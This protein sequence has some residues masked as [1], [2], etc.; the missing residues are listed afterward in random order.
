M[1][2]GGGL[3]SA[4]KPGVARAA[5]FGPPMSRQRLSD[6]VAASI[7]STIVKQDL[8]PGDALPSQRDLGEQ[9]G[10]SRSVIREAVGALE[11]RG[12]IEV[13]AGSGL[14]LVSV[15]ATSVAESLR[16][17]VRTNDVLDYGKVH[18]VRA[19]V[20]T[21]VAEVAAQRATALDIETIRHWRDKQAACAD[22]LEAAAQCDLEFHRAIAKAADNELYL[23]LLDSI[24]GAL[25]DIRRTLMPGRLRKT[26]RAHSKIVD[27]I[28][29]GD[30]PGA[31]IAMQEHLDTV[32]D[33]WRRGHPA[34]ESS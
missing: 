17:F 28:A 1:T 9:Y 23:L 14:R 5:A 13:R 15:D 10:V 33:D 8:R 31:R 30:G 32:Q 24:R 21:H 16:F 29:A 26:V 6:Q 4:A 2:E 3:G 25:L 22:D 11:A 12:V 34:R 20:E 27:C 7:L 18:E 19:M